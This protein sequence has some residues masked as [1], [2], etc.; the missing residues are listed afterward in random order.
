MSFLGIDL[1][2]TKL[3]SAVF[4]AE[5]LILHKEVHPLNGRSG[6]QVGA[7]I[8]R[9]I[10]QLLHSDH[11]GA[12]PITAVG[13]SVPGISNKKENTVWAPNIPGWEAYPLLD[14]VK[15]VT[16]ALPLTIESDRSCYILGE[17][18]KGAAQGCQNAVFL[19][20]GTGIGA[21]IVMDGRVLN[22]A[23]GIAGAA[24]WMALDPLYKEDYKNCG[25]FEYHASGTGIAQG[26]QNKVRE[27]KQYHGVLKKL[28]LESITAHDVFAAY[29]TGDAIAKEVLDAAVV[30]WGMAIANVVSLLNPEQIILGGGVFGPAQQFIEAIKDEA[31]KWAQPVSMQRVCITASKLGSAAGV[32]GAGYLALQSIKTGY[33]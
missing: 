23:H 2:G 20:I 11:F 21:G 31:S 28:P 33:V 5:G 19:A 29:E 15:E 7:C 14:E 8:T 17:L 22:G 1:G 18:W 3:A 30:Y 16:G 10:Q 4:S 25:F 27:Q 9:Q 24:G 32:Y 6:K 26:A 13:I 12:D